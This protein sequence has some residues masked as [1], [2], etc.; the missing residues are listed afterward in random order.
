VGFWSSELVARTVSGLL[1]EWMDCPDIEWVVRAVSGLLM[2]GWSVRTL[3]GLF[4]K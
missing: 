2:S 1:G 4:R 3:K